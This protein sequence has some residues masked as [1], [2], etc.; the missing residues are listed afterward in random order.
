MARENKTYRRA[1]GYYCGKGGR[2]VLYI[3]LLSNDEENLSFGPF[4]NDVRQACRHG[5]YFV[6]KMFGVGRS[7]EPMAN[8]CSGRFRDHR[9]CRPGPGMRSR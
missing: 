6:I 7:G 2:A 5:A 9:L 3:F 8:E 4:D 1:G